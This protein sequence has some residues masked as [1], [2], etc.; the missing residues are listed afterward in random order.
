MRSSVAEKKPVAQD[1]HNADI[2]AA[3]HKQGW[4]LRQLGL[5]NGVKNGLGLALHKPYPRAERLIAEVIGV[6]PMV[7]WP[8]RY[9]ASGLP[10]RRK[11]PQPMNGRP[12]VASVAPLD[13]RRN[14]QAQAAE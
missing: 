13:G 8:S 4:S 14:R 11:G 1:W 10:N 12:R 2:V 7:I 5:K 6:H 3:L 9:D